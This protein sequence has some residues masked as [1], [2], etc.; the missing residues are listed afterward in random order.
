MRRKYYSNPVSE[1]EDL[2]QFEGWE[3][4]KIHTRDRPGI[5]LENP[6]SGQ[7]VKL[8]LE[9]DCFNDNRIK[10]SRKM[11]MSLVN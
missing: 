4:R 11:Q 7:K 9:Q 1:P 5:I 8:V 10:V 6:D 2:Q 3:V